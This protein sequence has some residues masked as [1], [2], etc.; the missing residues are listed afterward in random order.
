MVALG[1]FQELARL[2]PGG[3]RAAAVLAVARAFATIDEAFLRDAS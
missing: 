1:D 3:R 2:L